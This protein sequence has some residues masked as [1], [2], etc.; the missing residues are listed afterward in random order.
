[1]S[2][3]Y[4]F[5]GGGLGS[6]ARYG[7]AQLLS[8]LDLAFPWATFIA[9]IIACLILGY[10]TGLLLKQ[11]LSDFVKLTFMVGFCG[12]FSTFSTFSGETLKLFQAGYLGYAIMN[13]LLS[14]SIS[15]ACIFMGIKI[16][17]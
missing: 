3:F 2:F 6:L 7:V 4:V 13:I 14:V 1:M 17:E 9:N 12:G 8:S 11:D 10:L 16:A 5:I 15:L